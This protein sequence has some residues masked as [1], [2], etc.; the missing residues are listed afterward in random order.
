MCIFILATD[1]VIAVQWQ[2]CGNRY[3][4]SSNHW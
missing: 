2:F 4:R 1:D 3:I